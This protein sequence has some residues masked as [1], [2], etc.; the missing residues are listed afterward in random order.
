MKLA[1][2]GGTQKDTFMKIG[3]KWF[4]CNTS[5]WQM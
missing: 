5:R 4:S 1:I 3:K 2:I